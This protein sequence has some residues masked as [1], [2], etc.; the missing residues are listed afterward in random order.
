MAR[1]LPDGWREL[2]VT[3]AAQREIETLAQLADLPDQ[4][5]VFH[6]VHWTTLGS[7]EDGEAREAG[8]AVFGDA[9]FV[10][11]NAAG[12]LLLI[13]QKSG[14]LSETPDGLVTAYGGHRRNLAVHLSRT[15]EALLAKIQ[16]RP[17]GQ[18]ARI[19]TL[20]YCPD[21]HVKSPPTVGLLAERIVDAARRERLL[22]TIQ[23]ILPPGETA[24]FAREVHRVL[25]DIIRLDSDVSALV[26]RA[27]TLVTRVAGGL[28][29]WARQLS[30][31][32]YR[33]RVTGT[34]GSGK[35][36]LALAEYRDT[37]ARG[38]RPLYVCFNRPLADHFYALVPPGGVACTFHMLC[39]RL[40]RAHGESPDFSQ[41]AVFRRLVERAA[42]LPVPDELRFDTLIVD[43]GQDF[44]EDWCAQV[45]R[46]A[47][48]DSRRL[49]LEDPLQNLYG[50]PPVAL[51]GWVGLRAEANYRSP[52]PV[53]RWLQNVLPGHVTIDAVS[54]FDTEALDW[55]VYRDDDEMRQKV[56]EAIRRCLSNGFRKEDLAIIS[57]R[58]RDNSSLLPLAQL[59]ASTLRTFSGDYDLFGQPQYSRGEVLLETVY[60]FKGQAAPAV[61]FAEIDFETLDEQARRKLF[62]GAT[63][64]ML[65]LMLVVSERA[66]RQ[67]PPFIDS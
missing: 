10:V 13:E 28:A 58:G 39:E 29:H 42:A 26:G 52:R 12:D 25:G 34:A 67:L 5:T 30:I 3:G 37:L 47:A 64:A 46:F 27:R 2:A 31:D 53:V 61:I 48:P 35:T 18:Q 45:F 57:Y 22:P 50:R 49:W 7:K 54:P 15:R 1:I 11:T 16:A 62:V 23:A 40:L 66:A 20:L 55:L 43:E 24:P 65:K 32:P 59:G 9:D 41:P 14:F 38:D 19:E 44:S 17:G 51:P 21:Y 56:K 6:A 36:Q 63:R 33:L 4:Y 60:R 8:Y